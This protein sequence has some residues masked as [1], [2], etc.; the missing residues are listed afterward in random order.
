MRH[1]LSI[2]LLVFGSTLA[3]GCN[4][5]C[6]ALCREMYDYA[7]ECG[8]SVSKDELKT[9]RQS[10]TNSET[11]RTERQLCRANFD[12]LRAEWSCDDLADY[13]D[14]QGGDTQP[15]DTAVDSARPW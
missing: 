2:A 6:Q 13:W 14:G 4:N 9:C 7:L 5:A 12:D 8:Y 3:T 1:A 11:P 15:A 10:Q